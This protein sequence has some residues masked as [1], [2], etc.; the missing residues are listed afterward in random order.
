MSKYEI[1][2]SEGE[3]LPKLIKFTIPL[4]ASGILQLFFNAADVVI[5]GRYCGPQALASVGS[6]S[7]LINLF[8]NLF[9]GLAVGVSFCIAKSFAQKNEKELSDSVHTAVS[10]ALIGGV[11]L[12]VAGII[13]SRPC[14][15]LMGTPEDILDSAALYM[16]IYYLGIPANFL[17]NFGSSI[18]RAV[19]DTKRPLYFLLFAGFIN[20]VLNMIF[21]IFLGRSVDGVAAATA[22]SQWISAFLVLRC[23]AKTDGAYRLDFRK[24]RICKGPAIKICKIGFPAGVQG[25]LF[26]ISNV[27]IQSSVNSFGSVAV[28]G[29]SI[30]HNVEGFV[31]TAMNA[32]YQGSLN[33]TSQ[34]FGAGRLDRIRKIR[35]L[36]LVMVFIV[37]AVLGNLVYLF[38]NQISH[39]YSKSEEV[40]IFSRN[41]MHVICCLYFFCG[42]MEV[43]SGMLRGL[44][45]STEPMIITLIGVCA[46][47]IVW[48][49]T[50]FRFVWPTLESLYFSW[51]ISWLIT[52]TAHTIYYQILMKKM[53]LKN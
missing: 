6:T 15:S 9:T 10:M 24:L 8:V 53:S 51:P 52:F 35:W 32:V 19:G 38:G 47:R 22:V 1:N 46:V 49:F 29:N 45:H 34:N 17:Y 23:I 13:L 43:M 25:M 14:L 42:M 18:L 50:I 4:I 31:Y 16:K 2:M 11:F 21:V 5:C 48:I 41:R 28:A 40:I 30:G 26:S 7:S 37:G 39:L 12:C 44:G 33:F 36:T 3:L 20:V 27:L